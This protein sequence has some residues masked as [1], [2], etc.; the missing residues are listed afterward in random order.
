MRFTFKRG[1]RRIYFVLSGLWA[2][3]VLFYPYKYR[4]ENFQTELTMCPD[5][6]GD[7]DYDSAGRTIVYVPAE[8]LTYL[9]DRQ[10]L[11]AKV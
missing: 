6:P 9:W 10:R 11:V 2:V 1:L 8:D 5:N 7:A 4:A 3:W